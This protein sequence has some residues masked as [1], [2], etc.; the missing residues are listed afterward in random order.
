MVVRPLLLVLSLSMGDEYPASDSAS[1]L[2][3]V[4]KWWIMNFLYLQYSSWRWFSVVV[5]NSR[6]FLVI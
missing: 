6:C 2:V 5:V 4:I 1:H 3:I